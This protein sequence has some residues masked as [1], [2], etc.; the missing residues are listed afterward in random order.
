[1]GFLRQGVLRLLVKAVTKQG[2]FDQAMKVV[3]NLLVEEKNDWMDVQL[4]GWVQREAGKEEESAKTYERVLDL[5]AKDKT[6]DAD[7]K[8]HYILRNRYLLSGLYVDINRIEKA[9]EQLKILIE[10]RPK[11]AAYPNDLGY[12]WADHDMNL[13][14]SEK[15]VR[16]ALELDR[17][18]R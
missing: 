12:I 15:L 17:K 7:E 8:E 2:Q 1:T 4:K 5:I 10:K 11:E 3:E 6:L 13:E 9:A 16:K 14:E 18:R